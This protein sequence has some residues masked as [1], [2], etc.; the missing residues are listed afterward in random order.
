MNIEASD[1]AFQQIHIDVARNATDDFNPFHDKNRW[2]SIAS[3][4]FQGPIVLGFQLECL[5]EDRI[6]HHRFTHAEYSLYDKHQLCFSN[7]QVNFA[8][9]VR[10]DTE[11]QVDIRRSKLSEGDN[12]TLSNRVS[13]KSE[14]R[15]DLIGYKRETQKP[16]YLAG[17]DHL[18]LGSLG[19]QRDRSY[20]RGTDF[21]MKRKFMNTS[22]RF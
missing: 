15:L 17:T 18:P 14:G 16:L 12:F 6:N 11:V 2:K 4:P 8:N 9:A 22:K 3:N 5:I 1:L 10:P 20:I 13:I 7:Y 21:F 19:S